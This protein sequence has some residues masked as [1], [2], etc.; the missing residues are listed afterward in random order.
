MEK[1]ADRR[2][3]RFRHGGFERAADEIARGVPHHRLLLCRQPRRAADPDARG[4]RAID[5]VL[6]AAGREKA[7]IAIEK[8]GGNRG[9]S[10]LLH[11]ALD[12][13][14]GAD[15]KEAFNIGLDLA[16]DDPEMLAGAPFRTL[17]AWP[18]QPG[19]KPTM[20]AYFD[21]CTALANAIHRAFARDLGAAARLLRG[22][23]RSADGDVAPAALSRDAAGRDRR[24]RAHRLRQHHAA[25]DR[26]G[27]RAGG[28]HALRRLDRRAADARRLRRQHR[29]LPDALD[30]RRLC[31]ESAPRRQPL[32]ARALFD[33]L[34]LRSQ[35][36]SAG[37]GDPELHRAGE[38]SLSRRSWRRTI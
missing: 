26:R 8:I 20:L 15:I 31:L 22:Q 38:A 16:P 6:R 24:R 32:G 37:R 23:A 9:Y 36:G 14:A 2:S 34:F 29:R 4:L 28:A 25:R 21:A 17:N 13:A 1:S 7:A 5:G 10:G 3:R 11:E 27:R 30:Q 33:R 12:P 18:D 19:F 35:P